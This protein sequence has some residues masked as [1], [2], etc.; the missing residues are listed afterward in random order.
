M[1]ARFRKTEKQERIVIIVS[2]SFNYKIII[3]RPVYTIKICH[4]TF[5]YCK[6]FSFF[7]F[8]SP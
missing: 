3:I 1:R 8:L 2:P 5:A 7:F 6:C 4:G